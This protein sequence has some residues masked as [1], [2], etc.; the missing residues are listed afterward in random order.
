MK[1]VQLYLKS[2]KRIT[3]CPAIDNPSTVARQVLDY[4]S[5]RCH[6]D[7]HFANLLNKARYLRDKRHAHWEQMDIDSSKMPSFGVS[8]VLLTCATDF[9][10]MVCY[11]CFGLCTPGERLVVKM[12]RESAEWTERLINNLAGK[13]TP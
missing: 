12:E 1:K 2:K 7:D 10:D 5:D 9:L 4:F 13:M 8:D 6:K 3:V 11:G